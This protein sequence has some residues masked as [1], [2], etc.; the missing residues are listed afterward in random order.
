MR[1]TGGEHRSR[2]L[3][4]PRGARTRPT[5]DRVREALFS[6]LDVR[7]RLAGA[8]VL[9]AFA[10]TGALGLEALSRGARSVTF[11]EHAPAALAAL[12]ANVSSLHVGD[13]CRVIARRVQAGL[14]RG[15]QS[16]ADVAEI[17]E[18][19]FDLVLCDPPWDDVPSL[20][21]PLD[22]LARRLRPGG[23][24]VLEHARRTPAPELASA[25]RFETRVWGDTASSFF[26]R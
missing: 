3:R 16:T 12:R 4:A 5:S 22:A 8:D 18:G 14:V 11:V 23:W 1:I 9:D 6:I 26:E 17:P 20:L 2:L 19:E 25:R 15:G 7:G 24:L 13:R 21:V 10:G